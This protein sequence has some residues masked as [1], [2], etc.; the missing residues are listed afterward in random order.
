MSNLRKYSASINSEEFFHS[1]QAFIKKNYGYEVTTW[2]GS[3]EIPKEEIFLYKNCRQRSFYSIISE[4]LIES[5]FEIKE[6]F[7]PAKFKL[8]IGKEF[9]SKSKQVNSKEDFERAV[10]NL[11][12]LREWDEEEAVCN[13]SKKISIFNKL[14]KFF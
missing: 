1:L 6:T 9:T 3:S 4:K 14:G 7:D 11:G 10:L 8:F 5:L 2:Y 13:S 12:L